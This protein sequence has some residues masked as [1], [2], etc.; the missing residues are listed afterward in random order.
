MYLSP[1][2]LY[3]ATIHV[4]QKQPV[5]EFHSNVQKL[6]EAGYSVEQSIEAVEHHDGLKESMDYLLGLEKGEG[7]FQASASDEGYQNQEQSGL[8]LVE[9]MQ[10][11]R[12]M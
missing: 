4:I 5:D 11:E 3:T 12:T 6:V 10:Q 8:E 7:I 9:E 1:S 2:I